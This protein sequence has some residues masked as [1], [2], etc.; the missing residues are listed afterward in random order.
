MQMAKDDKEWTSPKRVP[1]TPST[2]KP[3]DISKQVDKLAEDKPFGGP[4]SD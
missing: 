4:V 1:M 2:Q 3:K